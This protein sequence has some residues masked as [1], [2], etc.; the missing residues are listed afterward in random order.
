[1]N[2]TTIR[3]YGKINL[4][5][6][7]IRLREDGYHQVR[8]IMQTV[9][10]SDDITISIEKKH[11]KNDACRQGQNITLTC[12]DTDVPT[13]CD[14]IAYKAAQ[15]VMTEYDIHDDIRIDI[16]KHIPVAGGMAG[17][18]ADA[19]GCIE[20][21]DKLYGLNMDTSRKDEIAIRLGSDVPFCL[22]RGTY[23]AEGTG[24]ELTRISDAPQCG[25]LIV[26]PNC[27][28]STAHVY[29]EVDRLTDPIHPDI[30]GLI[31]AIG[32]GN[33]AD[34][35]LSMGNILEQV[36]AKEIGQIEEI[37]RLMMSLGAAGS[38]MSG[39]GPTVFGM[40]EDRDDMLRAYEFFKEHPHY[41]RAFITEFV[42]DTGRMR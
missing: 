25:I 24:T 5:L 3:A 31:C 21:L 11:D 1:M 13:G 7:V 23:L 27:H 29:K 35:V 32:T 6:D 28:V 39:S 36:T 40:Y 2:K 41:G 10:L 9:G 37:E 19:A 4:G 38:M 14:N 34:V 42:Y 8:M 17:G 12:T 30:D 22:R 26:N 20:A 33:V 18:S 15:F 16:D